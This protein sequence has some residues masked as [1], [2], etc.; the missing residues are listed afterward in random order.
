MKEL[1]KLKKYLARHKWALVA[2]FT[3]L[4]AVDLLQLLIPLVVRQAVDSLALG[5]VD[6]KKLLGYGAWV[7][8]IALA[9]GLG[10]FFWRYSS[11]GTA[12]KVEQKLREELFS[13]LC[14][15]DFA[16]FD[17]TK[18]GD[19]M[20]HATND[21]NAVRMAL[22][23]GSVILT[24]IVVLGLAALFLMFRLSPRLALYA[25]IPLPFLSLIVALFG[26][27]IRRRFEVVQKSF[28]GLTEAVRENISGIKVVKLFVQEHSENVRFDATSR[29]YLDKNMRLVWIWGTFFPLITLVASF[30]QGI[31]L[32][33]GGQLAVSGRISLGDFVAFM[34]YL[35]IL[36]WPMIAIGRAIDI[37]QRGAASQG[38]LNRILETKPQI[39][40]LPG[41]AK[42]GRLAGRLAFARS[43]LLPPGPV[44]PGPAGHHALS[45]RTGRCWASPA[46]SV[47]AKAPWLIC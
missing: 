17:A 14:T 10:R 40:D 8:G 29:D 20:A 30:S 21:I 6:P 46:P 7:A 19:L 22:G 36:I 16:Y 35:G 43:D 37:F 47:R 27:M 23:F 25:L 33:W 24:D 4:I 15:L 12:R 41:A 11:I 42:L 3:S 28:S 44:P 38:R 2:G 5:A 18:T 45:L 31:A 13:H 39:A 26:R 34:A 1:F 32:W 9:I